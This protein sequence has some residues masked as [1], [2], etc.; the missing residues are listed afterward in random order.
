MQDDQKRPTV[1]DQELAAMIA[2]LNSG[3]S[4]SQNQTPTPAKPE[5]SQAPPPTAPPTTA[6]PV[7]SLPPIQSKTDNNPGSSLPPVP[8]KTDNNPPANA[9]AQQSQFTPPAPTNNASST[10]AND[11]FKDIKPTPGLPPLPSNPSA[12][13]APL[14][15]IQPAPNATKSVPVDQNNND[16]AAIKQKTLNELRPLVAK[17]DLSPE[18]KFDT[19][20]LLIR[21]TDDKSLIT[22][23]YEAAEKITDETKRASALLD[24]VKE[25]DYFENK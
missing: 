18:E 25:I 3:G 15:P 23:A 16:L 10:T 5:V 13:V 4:Q 11:N 22:Q 14:P 1:E 7:S 6:N 21:S 17:L 8:P 2:N 20:L 19:L 12:N 24:V 9:Q